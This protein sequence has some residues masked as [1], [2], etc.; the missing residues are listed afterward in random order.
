MAQKGE[1]VQRK[2]RE[3]RV[4]SSPFGRV[5]GFAQ[6][7]ASLVYGTMSDS[8]SQ[9]FSPKTEQDPQKPANRFAASIRW[10]LLLMHLAGH[11]KLHKPQGSIIGMS[12]ALAEVE[13]SQE[14]RGPL[15]RR[16]TC[17]NAG[18]SLRRMQSGWRMR[19]AACG[20]PP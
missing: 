19:S 3:R 6:L 18:T 13:R 15:G 5:M 16:C 4:P 2:L 7:G 11:W 8:V 12:V 14:G 10:L 17:K 20:A 1:E 9:Y